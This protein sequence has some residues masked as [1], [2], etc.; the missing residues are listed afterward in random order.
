MLV[1]S[2]DWIFRRYLPGGIQ[3]WYDRFCGAL[4]GGLVEWRA[5]NR[6]RDFCVQPGGAALQAFLDNGWRLCAGPDD[7]SHYFAEYGGVSACRAAHL[8]RRRH[9][10]GRESVENDCIRSRACR[11]SRNTDSC[12]AGLC[13]RRWGN[14]AAALHCVRQSFLESRL[15]PAYGV[16]AGDDLYLCHCAV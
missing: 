2:S 13:A 1:G 7:D 8:A 14:G 11:L 6:Y 10:P 9:G 4:R 3:W 5:V 16:A 12:F 15:E